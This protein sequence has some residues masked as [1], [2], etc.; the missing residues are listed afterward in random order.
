MTTFFANVIKQKRQRAIGFDK[1]A[2]GQTAPTLR[3]LGGAD[4]LASHEFHVC[5]VAGFDTP[6]QMPFDRLCCAS[7]VSGHSK[8]VSVLVL[9]PLTRLPS[10]LMQRSD[11]SHDEQSHTRR[12]RQQSNDEVQ[13]EQDPR[14]AAGSMPWLV[15]IE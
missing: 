5:D 15:E 3:G 10:P 11:G 9:I 8:A 6:R 14:N 2:Q 7:S 13:N 4:H 12:R 1:G